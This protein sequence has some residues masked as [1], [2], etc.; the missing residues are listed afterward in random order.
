MEKMSQAHIR[1]RLRLIY[2]VS[3]HK[4]FCSTSSLELS[5]AEEDQGRS[6]QNAQTSKHTND[7]KEDTRSEKQF[8]VTS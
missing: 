8:T 6:Y 5:N 1:L 4:I 2:Y 7:T 3:V